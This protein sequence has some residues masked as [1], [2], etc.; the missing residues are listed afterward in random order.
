MNELKPLDIG[1]PRQK[2]TNIEHSDLI[3]IDV[4]VM[5]DDRGMTL[6]T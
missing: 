4:F 3:T 5:T 1:T 6:K 2:N